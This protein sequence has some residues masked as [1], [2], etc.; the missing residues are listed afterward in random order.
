MMMQCV[1]VCCLL[2]IRSQVG[3]LDEKSATAGAGAT[4]ATTIDATTTGST[5]VATAATID[6]SAVTAAAASAAATAT[7][8]AAATI[9]RLQATIDEQ[10]QLLAEQ[11]ALLQ[12]ALFS[13]NGPQSTDELLR[14]SRR[15]S[16]LAEMEEQSIAALRSTGPAAA[17]AASKVEGSTLVNS[18]A[19]SSVRT[20]QALKEAAEP[21]AMVPSSPLPLSSGV[22]VPP[23]PRF[24]YHPTNT[25]SVHAATA[26][27]GSTPNRQL[28]A[29]ATPTP[30]RK[31][32]FVT[33]KRISPVQEKAKAVITS[34][35]Q[36]TAATTAEGENS[37]NV[38]PPQQQPVT[39]NL[40]LIDKAAAGGVVSSFEQMEIRTRGT[41]TTVAA[42]ELAVDP[43]ASDSMAEST[44]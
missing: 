5:P 41:V 40:T 35:I 21:G 28:R 24:V 33:P 11:D 2:V 39:S 29:S 18:V 9:K 43:T 22:Y 8:A 31:L 38:P 25:A 30:V 37:E 17:A 36:E 20:A 19:A 13:K 15:W 34:S 1:C 14:E 16:L 42:L 12:S 23:T 26:A 6:S 27:A 10:R 7:A 3:K 44:H 32:Q 4:P